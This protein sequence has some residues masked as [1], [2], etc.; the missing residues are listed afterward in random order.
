MEGKPEHSE[1][2]AAKPPSLQVALWRLLQKKFP[3]RARHLYLGGVLLIGI[4]S[5]LY[6]SWDEPW[7]DGFRGFFEG[8]SNISLAEVRLKE[9]DGLRRSGKNDQARAAFAE[10]RV[11]YKQE[12]HRLGE[13]DVLLGLGHLEQKLGRNDQARA[14]FA[15]ARVLYK[16]EQNRLG[17]ANVLRGLGELERTLG[18]ND[19]ARTAFAEARVLYKQEQQLLGEAN[20]L[21]GLGD[22]ERTLGRNNRART[23]YTEAAFL[24]GRLEMPDWEARAQ[25]R[26][27]SLDNPNE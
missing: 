27:E 5:L 11:L 24:Y 20:V 4:S 23:A 9:A 14:A 22:L 25:K 3:K 1:D 2:P 12:Q 21:V 8:S 7:M 13:A 15:E 17:E 6:G 26:L 19:Q 10:A 18:R 16:Q